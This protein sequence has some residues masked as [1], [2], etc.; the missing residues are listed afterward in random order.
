MA[1]TSTRRVG[2]SPTQGLTESVSQRIPSPTPRSVVFQLRISPQIRS[3]IRN[4]S[5]GNVRDSW[6]TDFCKTPE[7]LPH[8]HVP[9]TL[10]FR[11]GNFVIPHRCLR[12]KKNIFFVI[13]CYLEFRC[14]FHV[15][16][17]PEFWFILGEFYF[18]SNHFDCSK[19][20]FVPKILKYWNFFLNC[21]KPLIDSKDPDP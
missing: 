20:N 19:P 21:L 15:L 13:I 7:N 11:A 5:K 6:G 2:D 10:Y 3:Q 17:C 16:F 8:C 9:L 12:E 4:D 18:L 14:R 1:T